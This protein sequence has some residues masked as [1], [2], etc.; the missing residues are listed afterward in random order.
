MKALIPIIK[1]SE[2]KNIYFKKKI[3]IISFSSNLKKKNIFIITQ[4]N[5]AQS[6]KINRVALFN[7]QHCHALV[8]EKA[9]QSNKSQRN[10]HHPHFEVVP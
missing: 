6:H 7:I 5:R 3:K 9:E 10:R 1:L 8:P 2:I 4:K